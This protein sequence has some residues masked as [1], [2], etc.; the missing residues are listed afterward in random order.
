MGE[1]LETPGGRTS[2]GSGPRPSTLAGPPPRSPAPDPPYC[3][4]G[5]VPRN[6]RILHRQRRVRRGRIRWGV[7]GVWTPAH[8]KGNIRSGVC[9]ST[10]VGPFSPSRRYASPGRGARTATY[11]PSRCFGTYRFQSDLPGRDLCILG[12]THCR[13]VNTCHQK[14]SPGRDPW[15]PYSRMVTRVTKRTLPVLLTRGNKG[16]FREG[17]LGSMFPIPQDGANWHQSRRGTHGLH[18]RGWNPGVPRPPC[19]HVCTSRSRRRP[20]EPSS[21]GGRKSRE[22]P[23]EA[24]RRAR[25]SCGEVVVRGVKVGVERL[26]SVR[27]IK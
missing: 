13:D 5:N 26:D 27:R 15:A 4:R 10:H 8:G 23:P 3:T 25:V 12:D 14:N 24:G 17:P 7:S 6:R 9:F 1:L 16:L 22:S 2:G 11:A 18:P 21:P 19:I 20:C